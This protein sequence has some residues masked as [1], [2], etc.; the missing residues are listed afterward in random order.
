VYAD[1]MLTSDTGS[2]LERTGCVFTATTNLM[3]ESA[4]AAPDRPGYGGQARRTDR[5]GAGFTSTAG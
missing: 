3:S 5:L 4:A 2:R 1:V